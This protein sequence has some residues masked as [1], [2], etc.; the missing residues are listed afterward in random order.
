[1]AA[2]LSIFDGIVRDGKH[3]TLMKALLLMNE[4]EARREQFEERFGNVRVLFEMLQPDEELRAFLADYTWIVKFYMLYRKKFY[5]KDHFEI[6]P[7]DGVKTRALI[8]EYVD[9][10]ELETDFPSYVLDEHYL[11]KVAP[12]ELDAKALDIG[13]MLDAEIRVRLDEDDDVRPLSERLERIIDE[14]RR[15]PSGHRA[16]RGT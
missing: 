8:R 14:K 10:K 16:S 2:L 13:A 4:D 6:T 1:M 5:P 15:H 11:T 7:E 3:A 12:L 9:V